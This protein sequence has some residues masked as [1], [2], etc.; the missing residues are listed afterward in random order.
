MLQIKVLSTLMI[1]ANDFKNGSL[2]RHFT[3]SFVPMLTSPILDK[4]LL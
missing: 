1:N 4:L 3:G 2:F